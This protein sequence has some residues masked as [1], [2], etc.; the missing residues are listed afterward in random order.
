MKLFA[1]LIITSLVL[2]APSAFAH[3]SGGAFFDDDARVEVSGIL[4]EAIWRNPHTS[5]TLSVTNESGQNEE[6]IVESNAVNQLQRLGVNQDTFKI[7]DRVSFWGPPATRNDTQ[8]RAYNLLLADQTEVILWPRNPPERR[9][10]DQQ[11]ADS[12]PEIAGRDIDKYIAEAD[13]IYRTWSRGF[14]RTLNDPLPLTESARAQLETYD[15]ITDDPVL[16]CIPTS[17]PAVMDVSFPIEFSKQGNDIQL[18]LEPWDT[19]RTIHMDGDLS[20]AHNLPATREGY[21]VGSW[22]GSTLVVETT[23]IQA[24][25]FDDKGTPMTNAVHVL[26]RWTLNEDESELHWQSTITDPNTFTEP[27]LQEQV[28]PWIPGEEIKAYRCETDN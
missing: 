8:L 11:L 15:P 16:D 5:F 12:V 2:M 10:T 23:N 18:R 27:V 21:S 25:H 14:I 7:G 13:G 6:W 4:T 24:V 3:H 9:W 17:M 22:E 20:D 26:E 28:F 19:V 1:N